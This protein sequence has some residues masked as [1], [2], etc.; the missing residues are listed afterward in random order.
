[1]IS[2]AFTA[3]LAG[4]LYGLG[5]G[6]S[7]LINP[8]K[9]QAF[10]DVAGDWDPS[11][12]FVMAGA[13]AVTMVGY[14]LALRG[15]RPLLDSAFVLSKRRDL[16]VRLLGGSALFGVGWGLV[17][18]CPGP[19]VSAATFGAVKP[20]AFVAAMAAGMILARWL[21]MPRAQ[22]PEGALTSANPR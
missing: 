14:R 16:D 2:R 3:L 7:G 4:A 17:G 6:V 1:M 19:A 18:A 5:F 12:A 20:L 21:A 13:V 9:V 15:G 10:L 8:A 11:L 22:A